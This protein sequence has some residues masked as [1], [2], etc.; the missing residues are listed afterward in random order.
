MFR[1]DLDYTPSAPSWSSQHC[2]TTQSTATQ[3]QRAPVIR[4]DSASD[5]CCTDSTHRYAV[6]AEHELTDVVV[7]LASPHAKG[8]WTKTE[9]Y[10]HHSASHQDRLDETSLVPPTGTSAAASPDCH[11]PEPAQLLA[12]L[13][14]CS[15][16]HSTST[17]TPM[18][19]AIK[20]RSSSS[21]LTAER[22]GFARSA[23]GIWSAAASAQRAATGQS[24][25][26]RRTSSVLAIHPIR[27]K[28]N[29]GRSQVQGAR[30]AS[31]SDGAVGAA[32]DGDLARLK[33]GAPG[34]WPSRTGAPGGRD[35]D[36]PETGGARGHAR[37]GSPPCA[38][39]AKAESPNPF[40]VGVPRALV[41][42]LPRR[43]HRHLPPARACYLARDHAPD[44]ARRAP[45][46]F[47][48]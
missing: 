1:K 2:L 16:R 17:L 34:G 32:L 40:A 27:A 35:G 12:N 15:W 23:L 33:T 3:R 45:R 6:D 36:G 9:R 24:L 8:A 42:A 11:R 19:P 14:G 31:R 20:Q 29:R 13:A 39:G 46:A 4:L 25:Q 44:G 30:R 18:L 38:V 28:V 47:K 22:R 48:D 7:G 10:D 26:L 43:A 37:G 21:S 5:L 41:P